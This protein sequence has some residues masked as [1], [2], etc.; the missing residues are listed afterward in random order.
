MKVNIKFKTT[1]DLAAFTLKF[2]NFA[3]SE[4]LDLNADQ[5]HVIELCLDKYLSLHG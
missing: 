2:N 4:G 5:Q 1:S 3:K